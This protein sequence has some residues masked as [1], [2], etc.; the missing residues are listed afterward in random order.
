MANKVTRFFQK[1]MALIKGDTDTAIILHNE[2]KAQSY[3]NIQLSNLAAEILD[4]QDRLATAK[5]NFD[6]A[7]TSPGVKIGSKDSYIPGIKR[8]QGEIDAAQASLD[9]ATE[10]QKY[11]TDLL[12]TLTEKVDEVVAE[13]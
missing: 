12:A 6:K 7:L 11:Y 3:I 1:S 5:E 13:K 10:S 8:A 2:T 4:R 9:E